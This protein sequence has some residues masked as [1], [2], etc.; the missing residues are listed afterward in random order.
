MFESGQRADR[1]DAP[2]E[3]ANP[4][5]RFRVAQF[6][7]APATAREDGELEAGELVQRAPVQRQRGHHRDLALDQFGH[8]SVILEDGSVAPAIRSIELD[9]DRATL[10]AADLID[11][12]FIAVER[13]QAAVAMQAN[14]I[15]GIEHTT[16]IEGGKRMLDGGV[17]AKRKNIHHPI[18]IR[19][20]KKRV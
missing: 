12:V 2:D 1:V 7:R 8:K 15:E 6:G 5:E 20:N 17:R 9:D 16:R 19:P 3:A 13:Q 11:P 14:R 10:L 18:V 4:F